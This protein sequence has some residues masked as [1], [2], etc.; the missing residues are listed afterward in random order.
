MHGRRRKRAVSTPT[1]VLMTDRGDATNVNEPLGGDS[2][3]KFLGFGKK[4]RERRKSKGGF[5]GASAMLGGGGG[6]KWGNILTGGLAGLMKVKGRKKDPAKEAMESAESASAE[7][8]A[9]EMQEGAKANMEQADAQSQNNATTKEL[10]TSS[11]DDERKSLL[12][13]IGY[14]HNTLPGF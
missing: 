5:K 12:E 14:I 7:S 2:P 13:R 4:A 8:A 10:T 3:V 11:K 6:S 1:P 9:P